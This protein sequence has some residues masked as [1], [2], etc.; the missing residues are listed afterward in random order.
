[1][2]PGEEVWH[3]VGLDLC[4]KY[5]KFSCMEHREGTFPGRNNNNNN[6]NDL[7]IQ[8]IIF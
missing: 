3:T 1:M 8:H 6:S 7:E 5:G 4:P 2:K